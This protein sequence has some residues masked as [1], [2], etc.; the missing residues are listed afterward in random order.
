MALDLDST[1]AEPLSVPPLPVGKRD[2]LPGCRRSSR[3]TGGSASRLHLRSKLARLYATVQIS[4]GRSGFRH[5]Q[6]CGPNSEA[7]GGPGIRLEQVDD[8]DLG[9]YRWMME[10]TATAC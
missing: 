7:R 1:T 8:H 4:L 6:F 3:E 2:A 9:V 10:P 5:L